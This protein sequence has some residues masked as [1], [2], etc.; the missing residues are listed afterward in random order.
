[1][2]LAEPVEAK[3]PSIIERIL[4]ILNNFKV[5]SKKLFYQAE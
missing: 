2:L 3:F 1:M 4:H 5:N